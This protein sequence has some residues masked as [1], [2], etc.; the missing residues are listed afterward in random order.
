[1]ARGTKGTGAGGSGELPNLSVP[2]WSHLKNGNPGTR[3]EG[4]LERLSE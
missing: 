2:Q 3:L 4:V 1:M